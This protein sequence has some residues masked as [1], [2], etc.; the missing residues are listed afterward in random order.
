MC[1]IDKKV[2]SQ[3]GV[4]KIRDD[5][6]NIVVRLSDERSFAFSYETNK[7]LS[8]GNEKSFISI[9]EKDGKR[10]VFVSDHLGTDT[11]TACKENVPGLIPDVFK[12]Y[13]PLDEDYK[14]K[15]KDGIEYRI[16][17]DEAEK[18]DEGT[19]KIF[20]IVKYLT[21]FNTLM[22]SPLALATLLYPF[23]M[24]LSSAM[25]MLAFP[26]LMIAN[27]CL[28]LPYIFTTILEI[29]YI[30]YY[31]RIYNTGRSEKILLWVS[32]IVSILA[33]ISLGVF[34]FLATHA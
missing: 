9:V 20:K 18:D 17:F 32:I 34:F 15:D 7:I 33:F 26:V 2:F 31:N 12:C 11:S 21:A 29:F 22:L 3:Y 24:M 16:S 10:F 1:E 6:R 30:R 8:L 19:A 14:I 13:Y 28:P 4:K 23:G 27:Y 25:T 5:R